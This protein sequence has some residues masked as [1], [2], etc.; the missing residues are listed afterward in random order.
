MQMPSTLKAFNF[1]NAG[2]S[3]QGQVDEIEMPKLK[4]KME[5]HQGA[6]MMM[7]APMEL[8]YEAM[9]MGITMGGLVA[10]AISTY[11]LKGVNSL[12]GR[13]SGAYQR[14][15]TCEVQAVDIYV[16]GS[17]SEIDLGTAKQGDKNKVKAT[18]KLSY[19]RMVI[20]GVDVLEQDAL[21]T[22]DSAIAGA[23]GV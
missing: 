21:T 23:I 6:G 16:R 12:T 19:F 2:N 22:S 13:F 7:P 8:G 4:K 10:E 5:D 20:D 15:D 11:A 18:I 17:Y 1:F 14:D 3:W 9:E